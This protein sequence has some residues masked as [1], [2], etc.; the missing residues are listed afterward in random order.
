MVEVDTARFLRLWQ[1]PGS[2]HREVAL[3]IADWHRDYKMHWTEKGFAGSETNPVPLAEPS[4]EMRTRPSG[5]VW[6]RAVHS[7]LPG[8][9]KMPDSWPVVAFGD[10]V[11]RTAWLI[12]R[13][14]AI[15]PVEVRRSIAP[16]LLEHAGAA[17]KSFETVEALVPTTTYEA[18]LAH[19]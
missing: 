3:G 5:P 10:G 1:T 7:I 11:T 2:S 15:F 12:G 19:G 13:G 6:S 8:R 4:C 14:A 16:L 17:E 18:W 9:W